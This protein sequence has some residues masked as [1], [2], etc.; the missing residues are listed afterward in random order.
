MLNL[1]T[2]AI[3]IFTLTH[4]VMTLANWTPALWN[5][6]SVPTQGGSELFCLLECNLQLQS[7]AVYTKGCRSEVQVGIK[8]DKIVQLT[9]DSKLHLT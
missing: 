8:L 9:F 4:C 6:L 3:W 5:P 7:N 1:S 2:T